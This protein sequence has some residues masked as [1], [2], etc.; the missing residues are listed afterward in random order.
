MNGDARRRRVVRLSAATRIAALA[1]AVVLPVLAATYWGSVS[2]VE[3]AR[4]A[5]LAAPVAALDGG[6]RV[7]AAIIS[8]LSPLALSWGLVRLAATLGHF[9]AG[10]P[11]VPA[12]AAGIR[13]FGLGVVA[14]T[15]LKL[16]AGVALSVLLSWNGAG[17]RQ[18]A[19]SLSS[20]MLL[21]LLVG[22]VMALMGWALGEAAALAEENAQFV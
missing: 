20:D 7:A 19:I 10:A 22:A 5:G 11:F 2:E 3:L 21:M 12:A 16:L 18:L 15:V 8:A 13:D 9:G 4:S 14:C 1:L 17:P 6:E